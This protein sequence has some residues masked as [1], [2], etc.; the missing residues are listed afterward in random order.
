[1]EMRLLYNVAHSIARRGIHMVDGEERELY[2]HRKG[3]TR[4][5]PVSRSELPPVY[6]DVGQPAITPENMSARS[7]IPRGGD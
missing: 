1:M 5:S 7:Y 2:V 6:A 4:A 3:T